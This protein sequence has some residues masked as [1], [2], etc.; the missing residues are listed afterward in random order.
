MKV[1]IYKDCDYVQGHLRYGHFEREI[2][3]DSLEQ[4]KEMFPDERDTYYDMD[5]I[6]DDYEINDYEVSSSPMVYEVIEE[7]NS[8]N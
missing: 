5:L 6:V 3:V 4:A 7:W 1:K 2:E 8:M